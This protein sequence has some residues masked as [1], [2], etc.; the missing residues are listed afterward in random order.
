MPILWSCEP[1][2]IISDRDPLSVKKFSERVHEKQNNFLSVVKRRE[3]VQSNNL[4]GLG[5]KISQSRLFALGIPTSNIK[6]QL[7]RMCFQNKREMPTK[8]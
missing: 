7:V 6:T 5:W 2:E 3:S 1:V 4:L 8:N